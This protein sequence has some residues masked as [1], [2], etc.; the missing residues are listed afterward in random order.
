MCTIPP[1]ILKIEVLME[2]YQ[3]TQTTVSQDFN[4]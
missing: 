2:N 1:L 3:N 4:T